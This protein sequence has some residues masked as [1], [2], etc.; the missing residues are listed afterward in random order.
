MKFPI[1][2]ACLCSTRTGWRQ[3][4]KP[5]ESCVNDIMKKKTCGIINQNL[6]ELCADCIDCSLN[7]LNIPIGSRTITFFSFQFGA[8]GFGAK[9][10]L[11]VAQRK[12]K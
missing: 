7:I 1:C 4:N 5:A 8:I 2:L 11:Q 3:M 9:G 12:V 6:I 10:E